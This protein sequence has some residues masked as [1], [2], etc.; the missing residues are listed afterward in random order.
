LFVC[1]A[2]SAFGLQ[3]F[4]RPFSTAALN[5][6]E[7][8]SLA[9]SLFLFCGCMLLRIP[10]VPVGV[11]ELVSV[12]IAVVLGLFLLVNVAIILWSF[13]SSKADRLRNLAARVS[14]VSWYVSTQL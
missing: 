12:L 11:Q 4:A 6:A 13:L 3:V 2:A 14:S 8:A 1:I 7:L 9:A 10:E 5:N